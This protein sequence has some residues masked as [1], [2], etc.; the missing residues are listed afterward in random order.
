M[1]QRV[2]SADRSAVFL[3]QVLTQGR[4]L[5]VAWKIAGL[6]EK[7]INK[8]LLGSRDQL[9]ILHIHINLSRLFDNAAVA[10]VF[11]LQGE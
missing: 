4:D 1:L 9:R 2:G 11:K 10:V 7:A 3:D 5:F 6:V 8:S